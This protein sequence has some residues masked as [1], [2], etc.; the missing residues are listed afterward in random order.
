RSRG[1]VRARRA[2]TVEGLYKADQRFGPGVETYPDGS[3]DVGLWFREQLIKLC[4]QIP[5]GFSL[6]RYP[7]FSSFITH[8]PARIS[9]SEEEKTEWGLQEGQD[10]FFYDYKRFLLNDNLTL[11]P[12]MYVYS[13]NSDHLP[14][15][16]SFRKELDT[17]IFLNEIPPFVEDGEPWFIINETPLLVKIQK[18]TY[19][20]RL[21]AT[22]TL[23]TFSWTVG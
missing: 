8:S 22:T 21:T 13:T 23:S 3:Q 20:F 19:K 11:P 10:P 9:L 16:S 2:R 5:S 15:T 12:E 1:R 4:T 18:Q 17:R 7:E 6:L 14:M